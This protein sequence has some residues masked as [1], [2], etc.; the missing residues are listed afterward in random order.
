MI[1]WLEAAGLATAAQ[2]EARRDWYLRLAPLVSERIKR[3]DEVA[4]KVAFLF[5]DIEI[6][7]A[8]RTKV[9]DA[10]GGAESLAAAREALAD[11]AW[12][13]PDVEAALRDLPEKLG[14]KPKVVFQAV[15]VAITGSTVSPPLFESLELLGR[16]RTLERLDSAGRRP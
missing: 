11:T 5:G 4:E 14:L 12:T 16:E 1:P 8:A 13:A 9:L 6:D 7:E 2:V 3:L 15:R 10:P